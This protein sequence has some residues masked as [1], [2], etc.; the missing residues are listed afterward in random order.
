M[1]IRKGDTCDIASVSDIY[2]AIHDEIEKGRY[3]MK[4]FRDLY[5]TRS[6]AEERVAAGDLYVMEDE[7]CI[8]ASA[9]INHNPLPEYFVGKWYQPGNYDRTLVLHSLVVD[10]RLMRRGYATAFINFFEKMGKDTGCERL[11]LDTQM[12]DVPARNLYKK[13][14]YTEADYVLCQFKGITDID[15]VLIE[16]VL[17]ETSE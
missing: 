2:Y 6:W 8:V 4:W 13:L 11:R 7:D 12:I 9:V 15:L 3:Q 10:P 17:T 5:P 1:I 16:K 14:G